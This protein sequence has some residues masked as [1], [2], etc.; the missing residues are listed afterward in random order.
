[1]SENNGSDLS[2]DRAHVDLS[3][4]EEIDYWQ[5]KLNCSEAEL[6]DAVESVG[7][8]VHRVGEYLNILKG[9]TQGSTN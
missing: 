1:M 7:T 6:R 9:D 5:Y 8:S 2:R 4:K 3:S